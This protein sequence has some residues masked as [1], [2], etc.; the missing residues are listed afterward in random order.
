MCQKR[1]SSS[2]SLRVVVKYEILAERRGR[3]FELEAGNVGNC[4]ISGISG[5]V[6]TLLWVMVG[7]VF[8]EKASRIVSADVE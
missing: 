6:I 7:I 8:E 4:S 1:T 5:C 2:T 3:F